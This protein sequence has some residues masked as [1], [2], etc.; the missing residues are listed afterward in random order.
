M[1]VASGV[2]QASFSDTTVTNGTTYYY[3]ISAQNTGGES[4]NSAQVSA[5]P[6][7]APTAPPTNLSAAV[8]KAKGGSVKL[9]WTQS[10]SSGLTQNAVYRRTSTAT[11]YGSPLATI[12][13]ASTYTDSRP[14]SG[15]YCYVVSALSCRGE[16]SPSGEVCATVR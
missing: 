6:P 12:S 8:V 13:P 9:T 3:V 16:S 10:I 14:A 7:G 2:T 15:T 11:T 1:T 4:P 5:T